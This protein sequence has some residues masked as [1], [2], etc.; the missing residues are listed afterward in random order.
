VRP[1]VDMPNVP[2]YQ[3]MLDSSL[4]TFLERLKKNASR[5]A[6]HLPHIISYQMLDPASFNTLDS[7]ALGKYYIPVQVRTSAGMEYII[8]SIQFGENVSTTVQLAA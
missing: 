6:F 1:F 7:L 3:D 5:D 2:M 4:K 8:L